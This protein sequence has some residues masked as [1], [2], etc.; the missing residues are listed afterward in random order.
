MGMR[1]WS[2][3]ARRWRGGGSARRGSRARVRLRPGVSDPALEDRVAMAA[4]TP[5][6]VV[7]QR[8]GD[9]LSALTNNG[10]KV[11]LDEF[12]PDGVLV[13][14]IEMPS[15][16]SSPNLVASGLGVTEGLLTRSVD[17]RFL[18][19]AGYSPT[20]IPL[21]FPLSSTSGADVPRSV[22]IVAASGGIQSITALSSY[23]GNGIARG[24]VTTNGVDIWATGTGPNAGV[25]YFRAGAT[26]SID[27]AALTG[28]TS[29]RGVGIFDNRLY[30]S[31][32]VG[33]S[34]RIGAVGGAQPPTTWSTVAPIPGFPT[35]GG[36]PHA[37][38]FADLSPDVP[39][40]DTLYVADDT[41]LAI[42]K[43]SYMFVNNAWAWTL[44]GTVGTASDNYRGLTIEV[45]GG[46]VA[47]YATAD[48]SRLVR[49]VDSS[50]YG[51]TLSGQPTLLATAG[52][53]TAFRGVALA[54]TG[55]L[56]KTAGDGQTAAPSAAF[57][58][59]LRISARD[60]AGSEDAP[61][62]GVPVTFAVVPG[63]N[64][65]GATFPN[66]QT[67]VAISTNALGDAVA[68][69]L[70]ANGLAGTFQVVAS[71][72]SVSQTF[73]LA[74][75]SANAAPILVGGGIPD[76]SAD[77]DSPPFSIL[78]T[79]HFEDPDQDSMVFTVQFDVD[80]GSPIVFAW[81]DGPSLVVVPA[82]D[83]FGEA[84][85]R[86]R[87]I[88]PHGAF[89][90]GE[91]RVTIRPV[92]DAPVVGWGDE[93]GPDLDVSAGAGPLVFEGFAALSPGPANESD[94]TLTIETTV[95]E[96][97]DLF[98][99][100][101]SLASDGT[102]T[103]APAANRL[104]D[105]T[106]TVQIRVRDDGGVENGGVDETLVVFPITVRANAAA[107][108]GA[109]S[110]FE[111]WE[112]VPTDDVVVAVF[113]DPDNP[114]VDPDDYAATIDWLDDGSPVAASVSIGAD[115]GIVV[116]GSTTF[117]VPGAA[118]P[119]VSLTHL[120]T[121][122]TATAVA[123]GEVWENVTAANAIAR[124]AFVYSQGTRTYSGRV[125]FLNRSGQNLK[126]VLRITMEDLPFGI[127]VLPGP[128]YTVGVLDGV[129]HVE[130]DLGAGLAP[131][132]Q[133]EFR[134]ALRNDRPSPAFVPI[135]LR[136]RAFL[137]RPR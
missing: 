101:P 128:G 87:A 16:G 96:G 12:T 95:L 29:P 91:F 136:N 125:V 50:G 54:P 36:S 10:A 76:Q 27:V 61:I 26:S 9:G 126:G 120:P 104:V 132:G 46:V 4:F 31:T 23:A 111:A 94:Q 124:N 75:Q 85:L 118:A 47:L 98:E 40:I 43:Y 25:R 6:N 82:P 41:A 92:N 134:L 114:N 115:G 130:R 22:A 119:R 80:P 3:L 97:G 39:G 107:L 79:D 19:L 83:A 2:A 13:Q 14:S 60:L 90:D 56:R 1:G 51:G 18:A 135:T 113:R 106:A 30:I 42:S 71:W 49:L 67:S 93:E 74:V 109:G 121:G 105:A 11:F 17:G 62:P 15:F 59:A 8:V 100:A 86:V 37:F 33:T 78:L 52:A 66:G 122:R 53:N 70:T 116:A 55:T 21:G 45:S 129:V 131:N 81:I 57:A 7:I 64:G 20:F 103:F 69:A 65:A 102:L 110:A 44:T 35:S 127:V 24:A 68:P 88:D 108:S 63:A 137:R 72:G 99:V 117:A 77:E 5:G 34:F 73:Q 123:S 32:N 58:G 89:V 28:V 133:L 84:A 112:G 38:A 48:A